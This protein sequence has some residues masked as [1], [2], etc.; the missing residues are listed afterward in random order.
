MKKQ[1]FMAALAT[2]VA[3]SSCSS[4]EKIAPLVIPTS[5]AS[6]TF[7]TNASAEI[8]L[9]SNFRA[10]VA[11]LQKGRTAGISLDA[12][13][14]QNLYEKGNP[15]TSSITLA[16]TRAVMQNALIEIDKAS[17]GSL[18]QFGKT[19]T[20]NGNGGT[21]NGYLF[22]ETGLELEQIL[23]KGSFGAAFYNYATLL[24]GSPTQANLDKILALYGSN[25]TF[26]NTPTATKTPQPDLLM[27]NYAAR[28]TKSTETNGLYFKLRSAFIKAQA[29]ITAGDKYNKERDEAI[30]EILLNWEKANAATVINYLFDV[31]TKL[32]SATIDDKLRASAMHAYGECVGFLSG[33]R[34]IARKKITDAQIDDAL[35]KMN[36]TAPYKIVGSPS[37]I[38]KLVQ[39]RRDL[40]TIYGFTDAEMDSFKQNWITVEGR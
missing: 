23:D 31:E 38:A 34:G 1:V 6:S 22:D 37:E 2:A 13:T 11:E 4:D 40:Q 30:A 36:A 3:F 17:K 33:F 8:A 39:I 9:V 21:N 18:Y 29:A 26:P 14:L 5:Y 7:Q 24:I 10:F 16:P 35:L 20:E 19:P 15:S 25:P 12:T 28:R 32:S 27:A